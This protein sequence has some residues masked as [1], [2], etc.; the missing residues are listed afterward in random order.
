MTCRPETAGPRITCISGE[1]GD[2]QTADAVRAARRVRPTG[3]GGAQGTIA[4]RPR[5]SSSASSIHLSSCSAQERST[6][7]VVRV[8]ARLTLTRASPPPQ[9]SPHLPEPP[10]WCVPTLPTVGGLSTHSV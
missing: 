5:D 1:P 8:A 6:G 10:P 9:S 4:R 7:S 3:G 2:P